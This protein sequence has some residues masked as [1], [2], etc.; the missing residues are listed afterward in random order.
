LVL[1]LSQ[2]WNPPPRLQISDCSC[3]LIM[4]D[5]ISKAFFC[6]ETIECCPGIFA[7]LLLLKNYVCGP[8]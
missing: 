6:R 2:W 3:F 1:L 8:F 7:L 4:S 5:V